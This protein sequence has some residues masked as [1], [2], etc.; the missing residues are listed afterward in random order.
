MDPERS[1][2]KFF[3]VT[4][5]G[6][7][8]APLFINWVALR[9][10]LGESVALLDLVR[11]GEFFLVAMVMLLLV[12]GRT[13]MGLTQGGDRSRILLFLLAVEIAVFFFITVLWSDLVVGLVQTPD[14]ARQEALAS[15]ALD[16]RWWVVGVTAIGMAVYGLVPT[17]QIGSRRRS[18]PYY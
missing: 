3:V 11:R 12:L 9:I 5:V 13:A 8:V 18:W 4:F 7:A 2:L 14:P 6:T 1:A 10:R 17:E 16:G 15:R